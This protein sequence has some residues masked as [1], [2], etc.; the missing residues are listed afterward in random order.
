[1]LREKRHRETSCLEAVDQRPAARPQGDRGPFFFANEPMHH[2]L[3]RRHCGGRSRPH[4][5]D[6]R[7]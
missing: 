3:V 1:M 2:V 5:L 4:E 7:S 6:L